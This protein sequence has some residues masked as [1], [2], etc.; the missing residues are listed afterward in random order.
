M[1]RKK[2]DLEVVEPTDAEKPKNEKKHRPSPP[3]GGRPLWSGS[4]SFGLVNVPVRMVP[5]VRRNDVRFHLLH[6]KDNARLK[7]KYVCPV[8]DKEVPQDEIKKGYEISKDR[9]VIMEEEELKALAPKASRTIEL[10][11]F[12]H[13]PD[14]DPIYFEAPYYLL[15]AANAEKAYSLLRDAM[16]DTGRAAISE[17]ILHGKE[18]MAAVRPIGHVLALDTM[19]FPEEVIFPKQLPWK[20]PAQKISDKELK[21]AKDLVESLEGKFQPEKLHDDYRELVLKAV[22]R[23]A[24]ENKIVATPQPE[25]EEGT[26]VV[27]LMSALQKSLKRASQKRAKASA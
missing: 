25:E 15:P 26:D 8:E 22:Q 10:L 1:A 14:I 9:H 6:E 23:K 12:V 4:I 7:R 5:A 18:H 21:A 24:K 11:Y 2:V 20:E 19:R 17:I 3:P 27:D 16:R 13:L